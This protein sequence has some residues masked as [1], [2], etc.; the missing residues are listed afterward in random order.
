MNTP[1]NG[2]PKVAP[3]PPTPGTP[4]W[5]ILLIGSAIGVAALLGAYAYLAPSLPPT[6]PSHY[7]A[8]GAVDGTTSPRG[9][10]IGGIAVV[11]S[12]TLV[13]FFLLYLSWRNDFLRDGFGRTVLVPVAVLLAILTGACVPATFIAGLVNGLGRW[14]GGT[15]AYLVFGLAISLV[16]AIALVPLVVIGVLSRPAVRRGPHAAGGPVAGEPQGPIFQC[17]ACGQRF[18]RSSWVL[19]T[20][21]IGVGLVRGG[22]AYY[23]RCPVCGERGW[24]VRVGWAGR[25]ALGTGPEGTS[26]PPP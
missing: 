6:I 25:G 7:N 19:L 10:V 18:Y 8:A 12:V 3:L 4:P 15:P 9:F 1:P 20:P 2:P 17:S 21:R 11:G 26:A 22:A 24:H 14:P 5:A 16:P 23:L 13:G